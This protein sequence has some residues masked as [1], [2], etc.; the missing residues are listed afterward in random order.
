[1]LPQKLRIRKAEAREAFMHGT[2]ITSPSFLLK[3]QKTPGKS[4]RFAVSVSKK[5]APTAVLRN[6]T[7]RRVYSV[8]CTLLPGVKPGFIAAISVKKGGETLNSAQIATEIKGIL[9]R[10]GVL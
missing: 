2:T 3:I 5:V 6:R 7:R 4:T 9:S 1:M 10:A 8:I